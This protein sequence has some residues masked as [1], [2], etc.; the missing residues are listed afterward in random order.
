MIETI[1]MIESVIYIITVNH[2]KYTCRMWHDISAHPQFKYTLKEVEG[3]HTRDS[4]YSRRYLFSSSK[5]TSKATSY[6]LHLGKIASRSKE[7]Y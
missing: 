5:V 6:D 4:R 3:K 7:F 1:D 2:Q